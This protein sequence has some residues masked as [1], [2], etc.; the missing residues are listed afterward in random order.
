MSG[1][2]YRLDA[3][4]IMGAL[5]ITSCEPMKRKRN[6]INPNQIT[7][8][9]LAGGRGQR[10]GGRDKGLVNLDDKP[11]IEHVLSRITPQVGKLLISANRNLDQYRQYGYKVITD[12]MADYQGPLAGVVRAMSLVDT[13]YVLTLPCDAPLLPGDLV[14]RLS[15]TLEENRDADLVVAHDGERMQR[16]IALLPVALLADLQSYLD[17]GDR[18]IGRWYKRHSVALADFSD[19]PNAFVN[20]NRQKHSMG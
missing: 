20:V 3:D 9:V 13:E 8:V 1:F 2:L 16:V 7:A 4:V 19:V 6:Q 5:H 14:A 15:L 17:Q 12:D 10:M 11:L 18:Q